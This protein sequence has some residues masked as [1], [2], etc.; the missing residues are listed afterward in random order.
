LPTYRIPKVEVVRDAISRVLAGRHQVTS[1]RQLKRLVE[2]E[3]RGDEHYRVGAR[4]LRLAAIDSGLVD[5]EIHTRE[6]LERRSQ[7]KCPVCT[8][9]LRKVRNM[10]VFGGTVTLGYNCDR[11]HYWTGLRKRVPTRYIFTR[12]G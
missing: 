3:V 8:S 1:Q 12:K 7:V 9:R 2:R 11:C 4:R 10:T 6:T 5:L